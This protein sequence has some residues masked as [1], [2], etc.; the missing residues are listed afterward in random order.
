MISF[1]SVVGKSNYRQQ[2]FGRS[3]IEAIVGDGAADM[4]EAGDEAA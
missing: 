4:C 2:I 3:N 1:P